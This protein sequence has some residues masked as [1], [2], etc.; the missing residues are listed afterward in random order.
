MVNIALNQAALRQCLPV[1]GFSS[2]LSL[3]VLRLINEPTAAALAYG[4]DKKTSET[5]LVFDSDVH[6]AAIGR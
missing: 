3:H 2:F 1:N 6:A 4:L 5:I